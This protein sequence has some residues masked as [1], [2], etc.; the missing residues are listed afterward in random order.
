MAN[1]PTSQLSAWV[2][3]PTGEQVRAQALELVLDE[4]WKPYA[5]ATVTIP[6]TAA[7]AAALDPRTGAPRVG[8]LLRRQWYGS[9]AVSYLSARWSALTLAQL[10]TTWQAKTVADLSTFAGGT[11]WD[12]GWQEPDELAADLGVRS[13]SI[14]YAAGTITVRASSD[15]QIAQDRRAYVSRPVESL[16][17]RVSALLA[18]AGLGTLLADF[19][20]G[21]IFSNMPAATY[22]Y[23]STLWDHAEKAS[24]DKGL[25]LWCD[26]T[27]TWHMGAPDAAPVGTLALPRVSRGNDDVDVDGGFANAIAFVAHWTSADGVSKI[28]DF[29]TAP[30]PLPAGIQRW[31][32]DEATYTVPGDSWPGPSIDQLNARLAV[33]RTRDRALTLTAP[34]DPTVR[35]GRG[36]TTGSPSLPGTSG[37]VSTVRFSLPEDTMTITTR[38]TVDA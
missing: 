23:E 30:D 26:E 35:P 9:R 16:P 32:Y 18:A 31:I 27:R 6:W 24:T 1:A 25:R 10:S 38:A 29:R 11:T 14:D 34:A 37:T 3:L 22:G 8:V 17:A 12:A 5:S 19:T 36:I 33:L 21:A 15:E 28:T 7:R 20:A 13:R 2:T 4:Q